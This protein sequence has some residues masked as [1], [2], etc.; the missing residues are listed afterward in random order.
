MGYKQRNIVTGL[1]EWMHKKD[2]VAYLKC[3]HNYSVKAYETNENNQSALMASY[4]DFEI[5]TYELQNRIANH[6]PIINEWIILNVMAWQIN[7]IAKKN[8]YVYK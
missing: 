5:W 1:F 6:R 8:I 3:S 2:L 4:S 7:V